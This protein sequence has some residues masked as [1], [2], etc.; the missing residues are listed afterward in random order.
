[1]KF[2]T[3]KE[4]INFIKTSNNWNIINS[5]ELKLKGNYTALIEVINK[6][7]K[8]SDKYSFRIK[9]AWKDTLKFKKWN[10]YNEVLEKFV[11]LLKKEKLLLKENTLSIVSTVNSIEEK[12]EDFSFDSIISEEENLEKNFIT[13]ISKKEIDSFVWEQMSKILIKWD[14]MILEKTYWEKL[15]RKYVRKSIISILIKDIKTL[16]ELKKRNKISEI[17]KEI[18]IRYNNW[19]IQGLNIIE[20]KDWIWLDWIEEWFLDKNL[21]NEVFTLCSLTDLS[22]DETKLKI[23][24]NKILLKVKMNSI[25]F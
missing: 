2:F 11:K 14:S 21:V 13:E 6:V 8:R 3:Q 12:W 17:N 18:K 4:V 22:L 1:M 16:V 19:K 23:W 15:K 9:K 24:L 20:N 5:L 25:Y 7:S 10:N